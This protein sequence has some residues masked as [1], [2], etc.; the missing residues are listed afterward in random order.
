MHGEALIRKLALWSGSN[1]RPHQTKFICTRSTGTVQEKS[2]ASS[3]GV[4]PRNRTSD[5]RSSSDCGA[6][7]GY[8][9][10]DAVLPASAVVPLRL[11]ICRNQDKLLLGSIAVIL[12]RSRRI[13]L[14]K[15][16]LLA[17]AAR[18]LHCVQDDNAVYEL[19]MIRTNGP[20]GG[21]RRTIAV[22]PMGQRGC[23]R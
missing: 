17:A 12:R 22:N 21:V 6:R 9:R 4:Q 15:G 18:I 1:R 7:A 16:K 20:P 11:G 10:Q 13:W 19:D 8:D 14:P 5:A 2:P 3:Q 23:R